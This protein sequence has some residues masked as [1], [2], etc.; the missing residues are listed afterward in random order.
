M[1]VV[2]EKG[3]MVFNYR[4][5]AVWVEGG[6][7]LLHKQKHDEQWALPGGRVATGETSADAIV[8]EMAEELNAHVTV[9]HMPW[10]VENFFCYD[11]KN[12]HE[13]GIYYTVTS[14]EP[15]GLWH[16]GP[17]AGEEGEHL[18][19]QWVPL[20]DL[21]SLRIE[22]AFLTEGLQHIPNATHHL[23]VGR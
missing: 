9:E 19:Y 1:D 17:F 18:V 14:P 20:R 16:A 5:A 22:P 8:R 12:Y 2:F 13:L 10:V 6:H 23:V 4:V 3:S 15:P 7:V 21:N 11:Q